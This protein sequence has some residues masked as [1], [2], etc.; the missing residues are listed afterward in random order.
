MCVCVCVCVF[1]Y[2]AIKKYVDMPT[3][4]TRSERNGNEVDTLLLILSLSLSLSYIFTSFFFFL[5]SLTVTI[6]TSILTFSLRHFVF[7]FS[8]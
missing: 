3:H 6:Y 7:V 5:S 2:K 1:Q 4:V 8:F